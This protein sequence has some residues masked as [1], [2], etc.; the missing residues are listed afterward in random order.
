LEP[1]VGPLSRAL[2]LGVAPLLL[3][4]R[5]LVRLAWRQGREATLR[6]LR[7]LGGWLASRPARGPL[8]VSE[9]GLVARIGR[10]TAKTTRDV[11]VPQVDVCAVLDTVSVG[12]VV[13]LVQER[14]FSRLPVFH[15]R[16]FNTIGVVSSL[17]LLGVT[18]PTLSVATV[19]REPL[20]IPESKPLP[21]LLATFQAEGRNLAVVVD[22]YGGAVGLVTVEDVVEEIVGEIEDE[23]DA[24]R[25]LYRQV[26]PGVFLASARAPVAEVNERF[27]WNLP[28]GEYETLGGLVLE[29]LGPASARSSRRSRACATCRSRISGSRRSI[30][31]APCAMAFPRS[32]S[33][34][35]RAP[36]R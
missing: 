14:G 32:S 19:M 6:G 7:R 28:Q 30:T 1:V 15:E 3:V 8:E 20:F 12:D 21:E 16:M 35:A 23:Y 11:M 26:A 10:F 24:P 34:R 18:D 9:A 2:S 36:S 29:R 13:A 22:E 4:E 31:T 25:Q 5:M 33:A 27:S 17:D